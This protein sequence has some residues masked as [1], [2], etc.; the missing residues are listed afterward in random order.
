MAK[1]V[2]RNRYAGEGARGGCYFEIEYVREGVA[3]MDVGHSCV[4]VH[5]KEIPVTWLSELISIA[6]GH[7]GGIAG[8]LLE[9]SGGDANNSYALMCDPAPNNLR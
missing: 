3:H 6:T 7:K 4:I 9:H 2:C 1:H 8:F 5:R